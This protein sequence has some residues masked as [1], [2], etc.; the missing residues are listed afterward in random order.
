MVIPFIH[1]I[2]QW[3]I[4]LKN[5]RVHATKRGMA[6]GA[7]QGDQIRLGQEMN[8]PRNIF[9]IIT[10]LII[11]SSLNGGVSQ[12]GEKGSSTALNQKLA[13]MTGARDAV[14]VAAPDGHILAGV[15][16][17]LELIP[18]SILKLLTTLTALEKL[19]PDYR[20]RT[21][22]YIDSR[23]NIKIKGYGDPLLISEELKVIAD[24]L[25]TGLHTIGDLILDDFYFEQPVQIPGRGTST[26]PYDA[27]NGALCVNFNTVAFNRENGRWISDE[28]QT[29]LLPSVIP[30]IA[31]SGLTRGR[32]TLAADSTEALQYT[33][34]LFKFFFQQAGLKV[35]GTISRGH[36]DSRADSLVWPYRSRYDLR[37]VVSDLLEYSNN[38]MANQILLVMGA[39]TLGPP[40]TVKKG[41]Q[42]IEDYYRREL[43]IRS[44][45]IV[46]AS[47]ISRNNRITARAMLEITRRYEPYHALMRQEGRQFYKTGHLKGIRTRAGFLTSADGGLYRFVIIINTP[48]KSTDAM[49]RIIE[50]YLK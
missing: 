29:P 11:V 49:M 24:H 38:F 8:L 43:K 34:E 2:G 6:P 45:R 5:I 35:T 21:D 28:P 47:G 39:E 50:R 18:A 32:I 9:F 33:G 19:G 1:I 27:P 13:A 3:M 10:W 25:A 44:G 40:G 42:V 16:A 14:V 17:D 36:I 22:F 26:E 4:I 30:K 7:V 41:L 15:H 23:D 20:F 12:A 31:A 37:K 48:G 46:E